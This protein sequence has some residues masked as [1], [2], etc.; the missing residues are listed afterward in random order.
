LQK[1]RLIKPKNFQELTDQYER[2]LDE[3]TDRLWV[4]KKTSQE[5]FAKNVINQYRLVDIEL[6]Y[7]QLRMVC[8]CIMFSSLLAHRLVDHSMAKKIETQYHA[9]TILSYVKRKNPGYFPK[10]VTIKTASDGTMDIVEISDHK[11]VTPI[12]ETEFKNIYSRV[13][14]YHLHAKHSYDRDSL[15]SAYIGSIPLGDLAMKFLALI[16]SHTITLNERF[17]VFGAINANG[18]GHPKAIILSRI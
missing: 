7:L 11:G 15:E 12:T 2:Y 16:G 6:C 13:C 8:E 3:I 4:V 9:G 10:P 17:I 1:Y 5:V 18:I 14:G